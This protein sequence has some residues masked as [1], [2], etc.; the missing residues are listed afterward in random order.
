VGFD[1]DPSGGK[2]AKRLGEALVVNAKNEFNPRVRENILTGSLILP[3]G[4]RGGEGGGVAYEWVK[5]YA[6]QLDKS[7]VKE[8]SQL[9]LLVDA[10]NSTATFKD[11]APQ[12]V[13]RA[14]RREG[15]GG[16]RVSAQGCMVRPV[17]RQALRGGP[18]VVTAGAARQRDGD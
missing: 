3:V 14:G 16:A 11:L 15:P 18:L 12:K 17:R 9:L 2:R 1:D 4:D 10:A 5:Q 6:M 8:G 13:R 7:K